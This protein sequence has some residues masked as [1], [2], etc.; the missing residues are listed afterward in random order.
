MSFWGTQTPRWPWRC[1]GGGSSGSDTFLMRSMLPPFSSLSLC[2]HK[3]KPLYT[4]NQPPPPQPMHKHSGSQ[5]GSIRVWNVEIF[6]LDH[7]L[8]CAD[9]GAKYICM[10]V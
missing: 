10:H 1:R 7:V 8:Q 6:T 3:S 2:P 9:E 4:Q 5:D